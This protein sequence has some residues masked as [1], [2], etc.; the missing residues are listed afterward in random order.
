MN[1]TRNILITGGNSSLGR[2]LVD[3]ALLIENCKL[4]ISTHK[5]CDIPLDIESN[6][7]KLLR[8]IDLTNE[9]SLVKLKNVVDAFFDSSFEVIHSVGNFWYHVPYDS[10]KLPEAKEMM[11]SHYLTLYGVT[12]YLIPLMRKKGGGHITAFS[13][14]SVNYNYPLMAAFTSSK[15][16]VE[17]LI[18]CIANEYACNN[19]IANAIELA[20]L[21]TKEVKESKPFG[22]YQNFMEPEVVAKLV[23]KLNH[24]TFK[25]LN[26]NIIELF[27]YSES[28]FGQGYYER[29][30]SKKQ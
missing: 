21:Q 26:G 20:S 18:K 23:F 19:I 22:D 10:F 8:N 12:Q 1:K 9:Q 6:S 24:D 16:A 13:C 11:E 29:N 17:S 4:I 3:Y 30:K 25:Y 15:A 5:N 2:K 7:V 14:N 27:K 28:F